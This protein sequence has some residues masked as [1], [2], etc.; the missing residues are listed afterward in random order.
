[1]D[2]WIAALAEDIQAEINRVSQT[3]A[4]RIRELAHRYA[5]PLPK[6]ESDVTEMS[7]RVKEHLKKM[8]ATWQ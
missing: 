7:K 8:G 3:L 4:A 1:D 6:L 5:D 2:K